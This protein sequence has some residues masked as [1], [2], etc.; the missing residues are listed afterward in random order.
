MVDNQ[1]QKEEEALETGQ[2]GGDAPFEGSQL[3]SAGFTFSSPKL[4]P[5]AGIYLAPAQSLSHEVSS[6]GEAQ[7]GNE[8]EKNRQE[9]DAL[10]ERIRELGMEFSF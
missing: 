5:L 7:M 10:I 8:E 2:N 9:S 3:N 1:H 4:S 6:Y